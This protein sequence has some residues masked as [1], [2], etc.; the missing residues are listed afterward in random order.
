MKKKTRYEKK[1]GMKKA[2]HLLEQRKDP[3]IKKRTLKCHDRYIHERRSAYTRG[4]KARVGIFTTGE[5][6]PDAS[7]PR[8]D[9]RF[10]VSKPSMY[11]L[12]SRPR[13]A[14]PHAASLTLGVSPAPV[15]LIQLPAYAYPYPYPDVLPYPDST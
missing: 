5:R 2:I 8:Q 12:V 11:L 7:S 1:R 10:K 3:R 13:L 4:I 6:R 15:P 9:Y 14:A